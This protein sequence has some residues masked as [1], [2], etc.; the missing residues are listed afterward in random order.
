M[1]CIRTVG[2]VKGRSWLTHQRDWNVWSIGEDEG[3]FLELASPAPVL[4][5]E[6]PMPFSLHMLTMFRALTSQPRCRPAHAPR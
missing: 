6:Y 5:E 1:L 2:A 4:R 3:H